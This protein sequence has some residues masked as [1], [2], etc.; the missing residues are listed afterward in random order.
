M[1]ASKDVLAVLGMLCINQSFR[2]GF[3]AEP[4]AKAESLVGVLRP[5]EIQQILWLAGEGD[6]DGLSRNDFVAR[7]NSALDS[8][9]AAIDCP[10]P[11]CP[12]NPF[13]ASVI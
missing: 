11:P 2:S 9:W 8:V 4:Q 7:L 1:A 13:A 6:T 12:G 3:F 10:D 5:D